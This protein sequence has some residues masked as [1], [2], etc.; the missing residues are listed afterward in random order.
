MVLCFVFAVP[1]QRAVLFTE[2]NADHS[3]GAART[4]QK[5]S[6]TERNK[7]KDLLNPSEVFLK[8]N[9]LTGTAPRVT[10]SLKGKHSE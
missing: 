7:K 6:Q 3:V 10:I 1:A 4:T 9:F 8:F 5:N 2:I